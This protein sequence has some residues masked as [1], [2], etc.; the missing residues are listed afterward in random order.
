M[1]TEIRKE[2]VK[3]MRY[4]RYAGIRL[5]GVTRLSR[6]GKDEARI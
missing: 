3:R 5:K 2:Y 1:R 4:A 6:I